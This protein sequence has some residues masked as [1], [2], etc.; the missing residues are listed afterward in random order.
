MTKVIR[1]LGYVFLSIGGL[2]IVIGYIGV[3]ISDGFGAVM[4]LMNPFNVANFIMTILALAPGLLLMMWANKREEEKTPI[5]VSS[6][7]N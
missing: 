1:V 3:F 2:I 4:D 5:V 7:E 6:L